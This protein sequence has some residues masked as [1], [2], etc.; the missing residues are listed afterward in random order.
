[1]YYLSTYIDVQCV[2][3][4]CNL[5]LYVVFLFLYYCAVYIYFLVV[6]YYHSITCIIY[7]RFIVIALTGTHCKTVYTLNVLPCINIF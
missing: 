5:F 3:I 6:F 2:N 1:M 4:L 7:L